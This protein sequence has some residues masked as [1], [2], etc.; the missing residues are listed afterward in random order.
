MICGE[1]GP[2]ENGGLATISLDYYDLGVKTA[3]QAVKI[4]K[5]GEDISKMPIEYIGDDEL[6]YYVNEAIAEAIGITIPQEIL[7]NATIYE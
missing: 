1:S 5:D 4:L 2:V 7:D 6:K 3:Q